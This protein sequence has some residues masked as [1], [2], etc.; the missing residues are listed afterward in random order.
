MMG[1]LAVPALILF[2]GITA[3]LLVLA[4]LHTLGSYCKTQIDAYEEIRKGRELQRTY[5][6]S[7]AERRKALNER[8]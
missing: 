5:M 1:D 8:A 4:V 7:V 6:Q 3:Y 2:L